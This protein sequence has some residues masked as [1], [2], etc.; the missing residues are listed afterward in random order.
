MGVSDKFFEKLFAVLFMVIVLPI[1]AGFILSL[2]I[3]EDSAIFNLMSAGVL[4]SV[5]LGIK[6]LFSKDTP[7]GRR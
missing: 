3:P 4:L 6:L 7:S 2:G 5:V 1:A